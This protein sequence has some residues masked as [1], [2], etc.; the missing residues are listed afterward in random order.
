MLS[1]GSQVSD[2]FFFTI[3]YTGYLASDLVSPI[4][5][6]YLKMGTLMHL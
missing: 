1:Q 4:I 5:E 6:K 3:Y 2:W